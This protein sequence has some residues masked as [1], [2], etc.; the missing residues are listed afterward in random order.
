MHSWRFRSV[1]VFQLQ[2]VTVYSLVCV[3][4]V[5]YC[6]VVMWESCICNLLT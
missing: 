2:S 6:G 3:L 1:G 5:V 4:I